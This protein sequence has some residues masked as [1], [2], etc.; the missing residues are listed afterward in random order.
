M[1]TTASVTFRLVNNQ[2]INYGNEIFYRLN[3]Y[4]AFNTT[5]TSDQLKNLT[6]GDLVKDTKNY[7]NTYSWKI[8]ATGSC[9]ISKAQGN[10]DIR[11]VLCGGDHNGVVC[12]SQT[13]CDCCPTP[14]GACNTCT[15]CYS[16]LNVT[17][18]DIQ[19]R[20]TFNVTNNLDNR[21]PMIYGLCIKNNFP[22]EISQLNVDFTFI[23]HVTE[24]QDPPSNVNSTGYVIAIIVLVI[25]ILLLFLL[26]KSGLKN[27]ID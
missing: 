19:F 9:P 16:I 24:K 15:D 4:D 17:S 14:N 12:G 23:A 22:F 8:N 3:C 7:F 10:L 18:N 2:T 20:G 26:S 21:Y 27:K 6:W 5:I 11:V 13:N 25:F 1:T